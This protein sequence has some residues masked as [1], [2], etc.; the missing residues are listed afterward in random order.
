MVS[1][2]AT[3]ILQ[4]LKEGINVIYTD[5][6]TVWQSSPL[7]YLAAAGDVDAI[8][9]VDNISWEGFSPYY[10]TGFMAFV[11]NE[12]TKKLML[13]WQA[14]LQKPQLN[15][16]I[17]NQ[18]LHTK[19]AVKHQPLPQSEFPNG[20]QFFE[21]FQ[22]SQRAKAVIVHNNYILGFST[23]KRRFEK[24]ALWKVAEQIQQQQQQQE[25]IK[26]QNAPGLPKR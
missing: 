9:H 26:T 14:A 21:I 10:C 11:S 7:P 17:F 18:I 22:D 3:H 5:V 24:H 8:L 12:R 1:G 16:A 23:R 20:N 4:R 6:D 19:S 2:R 15:Q 13:D 25:K